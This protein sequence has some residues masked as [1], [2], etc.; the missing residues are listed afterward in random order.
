MPA[1]HPKDGINFSACGR[2]Q[3]YQRIKNAAPRQQ[4]QGVPGGKNCISVLAAVA[5]NAALL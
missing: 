4:Q 1:Q 2:D 5:G 3:M